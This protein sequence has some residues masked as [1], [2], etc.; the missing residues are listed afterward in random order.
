MAEGGFEGAA[1]EVTADDVVDYLD[2]LVG[3]NE[4]EFPAA[5]VDELAAGARDQLAHG[6]TPRKVLDRVVAGLSRMQF[7]QPR[8]CSC[9]TVLA[10]RGWRGTQTVTCSMCQCIWQ[11][12][13]TDQRSKM[14][15]LTPIDELPP[16]D[17]VLL[18]VE[19]ADA[20]DAKRRR[21][22]RSEAILPMDDRPTADD[23]AS[24]WVAM[25][26]DPGAFELERSRY[27]R[28]CVVA[29]ET[30]PLRDWALVFFRRAMPELLA[31]GGLSVCLPPFDPTRVGVIPL[32][33]PAR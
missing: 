2:G 29:A 13:V 1:G 19:H 15:L 17:P 32:E 12:R 14:T 9:G 31:A 16:V 26:C 22:R 28:V 27:H 18:I 8:V 25:G 30:S 5:L 4:W 6:E 20:M 24:L 21:D 23:E 11:L 7:D 3:M 10:E 33:P